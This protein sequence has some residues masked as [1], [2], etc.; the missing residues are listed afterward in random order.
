MEAIS[1][2]VQ[3]A[4]GAVLTTLALAVF[5]MYTQPANIVH[6]F[7]RLNKWRTGCTTKYVKVGEQQF[8]YMERGR[9]SKNQ[10][11]LLFLHGFSDRKET[12]CEII[13]HLPKHLHL[14]AVD[15]PG[16][17][18]TG[19]KAKADL[20][21]E[22]YAAK[23]HQFISEVDLNHGPLHIVGHSM[24]G[25]LAGCYAATYPEK[26]WALTMICPGG[27]KVPENSVMFEKIFRGNKHVMIPETVEQAEEMFNICLYNKS[28]IPP[29]RVL[30]GYVDYSKPYIDF[31]KELFDAMLE[32]GQDGLTPYLGK[33]STPTQV[34]WGRHDKALHIAGLDVIKREMSAPLQVDVIEDCGH[35]VGLEAPKKAATFLLNFR[36]TVLNK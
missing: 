17:G 3:L 15:L 23:L 18:D 6:F 32:L 9:P 26:M 12:Y 8:A 1:A 10:P 34:M 13:M 5:V 31:N 7:L 11:S 33:I 24:G 14:I 19:I 27:V 29:K 21:V 4:G 2:V 16:H 20:T 25:G 22:A 36:E 30:Q 35:T 28:L